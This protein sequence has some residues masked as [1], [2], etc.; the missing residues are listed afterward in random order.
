MA[1]SSC[2][3]DKWCRNSLAPLEGVSQ[4]TEGIVSGVAF[5]KGIKSIS[6]TNTPSLLSPWN[7]GFPEWWFGGCE[8]NK[9]MWNRQ[10]LT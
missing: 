7:F 2:L 6:H 8:G 4:K 3:E 5:F 9:G 10:V 1:T